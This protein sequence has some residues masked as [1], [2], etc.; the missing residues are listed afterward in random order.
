M[1]NLS[2]FLLKCLI[3]VF[4]YRLAKLRYVVSWVHMGVW[5]GGSF[6][7]NYFHKFTL[8]RF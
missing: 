5:E 2:Q 8:G 4:A 6:R 1:E 3:L 7:Y